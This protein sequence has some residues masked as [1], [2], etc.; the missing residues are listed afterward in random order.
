MAQVFARRGRHIVLFSDPS[1]EE[2]RKN[3]SA[4]VVAWI[5]ELE[6]VHI[7]TYK[8]AS[9]RYTPVVNSLLH[10]VHANYNSHSKYILY[11]AGV[12]SH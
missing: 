4:L 8:I 6:Y 3:K 9:L 1:G 7:S 5:K 2:S 11:R 10:P 12:C